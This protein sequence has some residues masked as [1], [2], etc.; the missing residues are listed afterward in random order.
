MAD[1]QSVA[2]K[3]QPYAK[4][5]IGFAANPY[6]T[7]AK[8]AAPK[9]KSAV[10]K[11]TGQGS[12]GL[13]P[14]AQ[15]KIYNMPGGGFKIVPTLK[16]TPKTISQTQNDIFSGIS[17]NIS[18]GGGGGDYPAQASPFSN[19]GSN[20]NLDYQK[21][22]RQQ[23]SQQQNINKPAISSLEASRT[24]LQQRYDNLIT[25]IKGNQT[26]AENRQTVTTQNELGQRGLLPS[27]TLA[28]QEL[29]N[30]LNP[31]TQQY[32]GLL[33]EA[34]AGRGSELANIDK[35]IA[36][37]R[38]GGDQEATNRSLDL[39]KTYNDLDYRNTLL[40][41]VTLPESRANMQNIYSLIGE[42]GAGGQSGD[43]LDY[44]QYLRQASGGGGGTG[45]RPPLST[46]EG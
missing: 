20:Q 12:T 38:S 14:Y 4:K 39:F 36:A 32:T 44:L 3:L 30:A 8:A 15:S 9:V 6:G 46:F 28:Q 5:A 10:N 35:A 17:S 23:L 29:T 45:G 16:A 7:V 19:G 11:V 27:S 18:S 42:R 40:N 33:G 41:Q 1:F 13:T 21:I 43:I 26:T 24:P 22:L 37:L 34:E 25:S 2:N 31:I